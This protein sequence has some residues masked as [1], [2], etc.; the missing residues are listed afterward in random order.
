MCL[1]HLFLNH[2]PGQVIIS[3][4]G[5]IDKANPI[6]WVAKSINCSISLSTASMRGKQ[7]QTI[8]RSIIISGLIVFFFSFGVLLERTLNSGKKMR[9]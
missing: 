1:E 2:P 5:N 3:E 4:A 7:R 9:H 8:Y 6:L